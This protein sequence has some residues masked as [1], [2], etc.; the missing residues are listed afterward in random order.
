QL[1]RIST[2]EIAAVAIELPALAE[3]RRIASGLKESL[4]AVEAARQAAEDRLDAAEALPTA[5]LREVFEGSRAGGWE[6]RTLGE[7]VQ[8]NGQYGTSQRSNAEAHG[9]P[10]LGMP[11]IH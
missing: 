7:M 5:Y 1:P 2:D 3:Q 6:I 4:T 10:V 8:G 11:Q 9:L